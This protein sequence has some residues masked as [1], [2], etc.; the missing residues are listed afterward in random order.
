MGSPLLA[1]VRSRRLIKIYQVFISLLISGKYLRHAHNVHIINIFKK[2][3]IKCVLT[4][5][6]SLRNFFCGTGCHSSKILLMRKYLFKI[7]CHGF[8]TGNFIL[9]KMCVPLLIPMIELNSPKVQNPS[10]SKAEK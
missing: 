3:I 1:V 10:L 7:N 8:W 6:N 4:I 2:A 5:S 9:P